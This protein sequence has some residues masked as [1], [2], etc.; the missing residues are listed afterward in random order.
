MKLINFHFKYLFSKYNLICFL[1]MILLLTM[2]YSFCIYDLNESL[3]YEEVINYYFENA[4]YYNKIILIIIS[5]FLF[6]R[7]C[8][9]K[10]EY[11]V[12]IVCSAGYSKKDNYR[13]MIICNLILLLLI[14]FVS[15]ILFIIIGMIF[16]DYIYFNMRIYKI[17]I[18][19]VILCS[20]YG[21]LSYTIMKLFNNF[22]IVIIVFL[23]YIM[24]DL[25]IDIEEIKYLYLYIFPNLKMKNGD[26][27]INYIYCLFL[28]LVL[29]FTNKY[30]YIKKDINS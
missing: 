5:I 7:L 4:I 21:L 3:S 6:S 30:L 14:S 13:S 27:Y 26:F 29:Y 16:K 1:I 8:S 11:I 12:N 18:N 20:Y 9:I 10:Y 25:F 23:F 17:F 28:L 15:L 24:S 22:L 2:C 19:L